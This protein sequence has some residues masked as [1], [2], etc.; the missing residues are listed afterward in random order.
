MYIHPSMLVILSRNEYDLGK[1]LKNF[2]I[3]CHAIYTHQAIDKDTS[4]N[5][6]NRIQYYIVGGNQ[7]GLFQIGRMSGVIT[8]TRPVSYRDTPN[9]GGS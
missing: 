5:D 2:F 8:G 6:N 7:N 4:R 3:I 9:Q 1:K